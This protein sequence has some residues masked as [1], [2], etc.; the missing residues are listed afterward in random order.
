MG[1]QP[2]ED[3]LPKSGFSNYKLIR[4]AAIRALELGNGRK[5]MV[6]APMNQKLAT[7]ALEEI[8]S[9]KLCLSSVADQ[10]DP[11]NIKAAK[12]KNGDEE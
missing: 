8:L 12:K 3:L 6:D 11:A 1:Y 2:L 10:F 7:T 5:S 4:M 9:G